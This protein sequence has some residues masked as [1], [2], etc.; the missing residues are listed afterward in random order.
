MKYYVYILQCSDESLYTGY[1]NDLEKRIE[2][3]NNKKGAKYTKPRTPVS[4]K[5][6]EKFETK[7]EALKREY[8]IKQLTRKEKLKI[9]KKACE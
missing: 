3:H 5:Y 6:Y 4:L 1:T 7:S 9:I 8:E 2:T